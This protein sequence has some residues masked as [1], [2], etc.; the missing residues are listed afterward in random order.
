MISFGEQSLSNASTQARDF[1]ANTSR[2]PRS[3][4]SED[5]KDLTVMQLAAWLDITVDGLLKAVSN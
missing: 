4:I 5:S 2:T 1:S 3:L